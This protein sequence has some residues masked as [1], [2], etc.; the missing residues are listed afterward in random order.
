MCALK[1]FAVI[2]YASHSNSE[3]S[4][5]NTAISYQYDSLIETE[6]LSAMCESCSPVISMN[7]HL[8]WT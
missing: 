1:F 6:A 7:N 3:C 4:R 2:L 5:L 8:Q